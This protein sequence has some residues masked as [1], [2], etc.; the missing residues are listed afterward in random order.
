MSSRRTPTCKDGVAHFNAGRFAAAA[1]SFEAAAAVNGASAD[2]HCFLAQAY[3]SLGRL[4]RA[5]RHLRKSYPPRRMPAQVLMTLGELLSRSGR[6]KDALTCLRRAA[7]RLPGSAEA[8]RKLGALCIEAGL[9]EEA[10][11]HLAKAA[12]DAAAAFLL[13]KCRLLQGR[14]VEAEHAL[15][16]AVGL[17]P[18]SAE[19]RLLLGKALAAQDR[20]DEAADAYG[21]AARLSPDSAEKRKLLFQIGRASQE[22]GRRG[23][24][25]TAFTG[26][27]K[28]EARTRPGPPLERLRAL[29]A[30]ERYAEAIQEAERYID[31]WDPTQEYE[32][33]I[34]PWA[35]RWLVTCDARW[36][37]RQIALLDALRSRGGINS[38]WP[39]IWRGVLLCHR[40]RYREALAHFDAVAEFPRKRYGWIRYLGGAWRLRLDAHAAAI[41]DLR[42]ALDAEPG[43][44]WARCHLAEARL[45]QGRTKEAF[46]EFAAAEAKAADDP[47][48]RANIQCWRGEALLWLGRYRPA[49]K[50]LDRAV[51]GNVRLARCW[52]GAARMLLGDARGALPDLDLALAADPYDREALTWRGEAKRRLGHRE[53]A[54]ADLN[55]AVELGGGTWALVNRALIWD[56]LGEEEKLWRDCERISRDAVPLTRQSDGAAPLLERALAAARGIRR[57]ESYLAPL[58]R[59]NRH[60][61]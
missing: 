52:R 38:P 9:L 19:C 36:A 44:W 60:S 30:L 10:E 14:P 51:A 53:E 15:R 25:R 7:A 18:K 50:D 35:G 26:L 4:D 48:A 40:W 24:M 47:S 56:A 39:L 31:G 61:R 21:A 8:R 17:D 13:G 2:T 3:A 1:R 29:I 57:P 59:L 45:C 23:R 37:Q 55:R 33:L 28:L 58:L 6:R 12:G 34:E 54:L 32:P 20:R 27:L 42:A 16:R 41:E 46:S 11:K 22:D 43:M 49:L 5:V